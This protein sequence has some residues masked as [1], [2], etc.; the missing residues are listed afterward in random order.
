MDDDVDDFKCLKKV[1]GD[2]WSWS[3]LRSLGECGGI[4]EVS[5]SRSLIMT[6]G[7]NLIFV[8]EPE[9]WGK[10]LDRSADVTIDKLVVFD[11][12]FSSTLDSK[13]GWFDVGKGG[14]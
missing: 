4:E 10:G 5:E 7:L 11:F 12:V 3:S 2:E 1:L 14:F 8:S 9:W 13:S 6:F